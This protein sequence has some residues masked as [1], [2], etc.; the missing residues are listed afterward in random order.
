MPRPKATQLRGAL[1]ANLQNAMRS[2]RWRETYSAA[3]W[4]VASLRD[5]FD[6]D[7]AA[8][9]RARRLRQNVSQRPR[10]RDAEQPSMVREVAHARQNVPS[11]LAKQP[12]P[13]VDVIEKSPQ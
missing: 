10:Q 9:P 11:A 8:G 3:P 13:E 1:P 12:A 6:A 5:E 2:C 4:C 7:T